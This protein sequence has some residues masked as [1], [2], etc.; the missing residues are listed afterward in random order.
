MTTLDTDSHIL[1]LFAQGGPA[2]IAASLAAPTRAPQVEGVVGEAA[3]FL[4][5]SGAPRR[6]AERARF[7][8][9]LL[10]GWVPS[11]EGE[12]TLRVDLGAGVDS[13]HTRPQLMFA[14]ACC[15]ADAAGVGGW[16]GV[17][18]LGTAR[19]PFLGQAIP[20][21]NSQSGGAWTN[22]IA[23]V[24]CCVNTTLGGSVSWTEGVS[25]VKVG[26]DIFDFWSLPS[27]ALIVLAPWRRS[28][29]AHRLMEIGEQ[30]GWESIANK[31]KLENEA[32]NLAATLREI[33]DGTEFC[34][35]LPLVLPFE[36]DGEVSV[37]GLRIE[38]KGEIML[39]DWAGPAWVGDWSRCS[40]ARKFWVGSMNAAFGGGVV[41]VPDDQEWWLTQPP[42]SW[43]A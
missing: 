5:R 31:P 26:A 36:G 20:T 15:L 30:L 13:F 34:G 2:F 35:I 43:A 6:R 18:G 21:K 3:I 9:Q 39:F 8:L 10:A 16:R 1:S 11:E 12:Q 17:Q 7:V 27:V 19:V 23:A 24:L 25:S 22:A 37:P 42:A 33:D 29:V 38:R 32:V 41:P 4:G 40:P 28:M 14:A